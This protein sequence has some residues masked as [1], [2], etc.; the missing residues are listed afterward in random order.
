MQTCINMYLNCNILSLKLCELCSLPTLLE[1]HGLSNKVRDL[2]VRLLM[3]Q[4]CLT[5]YHIFYA[6]YT[7]MYTMQRQAEEMIIFFNHPSGLNNGCAC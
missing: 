7:P 6:V 2:F 3:W 4:V 5:D 1:P